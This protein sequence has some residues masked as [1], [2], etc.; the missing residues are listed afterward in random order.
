MKT[1]TRKINL[2]QGRLENLKIRLGDAEKNGCTQEEIDDMD[3]ELRS[4][5][6]GLKLLQRKRI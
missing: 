6:A 5:R 2:I 4:V 3:E 1:H